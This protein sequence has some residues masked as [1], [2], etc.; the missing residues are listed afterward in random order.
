MKRVIVFG[1]TSAIAEAFCRLYCQEPAHL[2]LVG[3]NEAKLTAIADDLRT[4][5]ATHG[6]IVETRLADLARLDDH[7]ALVNGGVMALGAVDIALVAHG[8]LPV[9]QDCDRDPALAMQAISNNGTS[10]V[11]LAFHLALQL[12]RQGS[13]SLVVIGSV[14]G[15]RG[16]QSNYA[17]GAAK[18]LVEA[19]MSG[20]R[21]RL[22]RTGVQV[23]LIKPGFVDTPMTQDFA[24]KGILWAKPDRIAKG[25]WRAIETRRNVV[26]LPGFWQL[27]MLVIRHIPEP[28][29]KRLNL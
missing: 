12:E 13:G 23:L 21:N 14:A 19:A 20:L 27:I 26:Y 9:Q 28:I 1:A 29:F 6:V 25:I 11:S 2:V 15:D 5:G 17:Y 22:S 10:A 16:R 7:N 24:K 4:R 3:R 8:S 18:A